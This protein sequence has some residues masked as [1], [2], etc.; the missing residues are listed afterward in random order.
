MRLRRVVRSLGA[1]TA[2]TLLALLSGCGADGDRA[3][4]SNPQ[5]KHLRV[6]LFPAGNTLPVHAAVT[7]GIFERNGLMVDVTEGQD[8]PLF[9]A[10]QSQG[11]YDIAMSTPTLVLLGAQKDLDLH[12]VSSTAQQSRERPNAVWITKDQS[13]R[14]LAELK[15]KTI[16]VPSLTGIIIDSVVYLLQRDGVQRHDVR[17]VQ[18]PFPAM[19]DQLQAGHV[20]AAIATLPYSTAISARGFHVHDDVIVEAVHD[21]SDGTIDNAIT[22]V[23]SAPRQFAVDDPE[24][25]AAWRTSLREA[26]EF[27]DDNPSDARALMAEWLKIPA[28]VLEQAPLPDWTVDITPQQLVPYVGIARTVGSIDSD[29]DVNSLVWQGP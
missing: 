15:G 9:M 6:A 3:A 2:V 4:P 17:F 18:T 1:L 26:I 16:A 13:I 21:A 10:A 24:A 23:W 8:L 28:D 27:L 5:L 29:P 22:T 14:T 25:V 12:I 20:D 11:Q 7:R 19:G